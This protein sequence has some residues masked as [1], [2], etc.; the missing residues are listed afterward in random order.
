MSQGTKRLKG[1]N[2]TWAPFEQ[3]KMVLRNFSFFPKTFTKNVCLHSQQLRR[4][5][6]SVVNDYADIVLA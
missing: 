1:Q 2:S 3:A 4:Y 6:V 5:D